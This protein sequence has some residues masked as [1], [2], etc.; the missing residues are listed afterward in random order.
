[1]LIN[2]NPDIDFDNL[3]TR[4]ADQLANYKASTDSIKP[5]SFDADKVLPPKVSNVDELLA[6]E[7]EEFIEYAYQLILN[8]SADHSGLAY[9]LDQLRTGTEKTTILGILCHSAEG[10][11]NAHLFSG[12]KKEMLKRRLSKLPVAGRIFAMLFTLLTASPFRRHINAKFNHYYRLTRDYGAHQRESEIQIQAL[13]E[14][15]LT[16]RKRQNANREQLLNKIEQQDQQLK[17]QQDLIEQLEIRIQKL[18][19]DS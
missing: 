17:H 12:Y 14:E 8:R 2:N 10:Q 18:E 1:M 5:P 15:Q 3:N 9:Y 16:Q 7:D 11:P 13:L 6:L 19:S 4:I